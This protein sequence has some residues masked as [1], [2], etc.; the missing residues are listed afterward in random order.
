MIK[1]GYFRAVGYSG[2]KATCNIK[3][4]FQGEEGDQGPHRGQDAEERGGTYPNDMVGQHIYIV[5]PITPQR[6]Q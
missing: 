4:E 5:E 1:S 6:R 3:Q 2:Y